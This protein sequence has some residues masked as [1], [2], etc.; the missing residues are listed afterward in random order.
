MYNPDNTLAKAIGATLVKVTREFPDQIDLHTD[1]GVLRLVADGDCCSHSWFES[2]ESDAEGGEI[3]SID[4][5]TAPVN[6]ANAWADGDERK[7]Y[8]PLVKT[9]KGRICIE[10]RNESN[11]YYGG[12]IIPTWDPAG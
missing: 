8:F 6:A 12:Y 4:F 3:T 10:M 11:G 7:V 9:T 5:D 2:F 1:R